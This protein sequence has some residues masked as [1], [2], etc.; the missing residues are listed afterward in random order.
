MRGFIKV[1]AGVAIAVSCIAIV[2]GLV[3]IFAQNGKEQAQAATVFGSGLAKLPTS[4]KHNFRARSK[5]QR[6]RKL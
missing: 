3:G 2:T 4:G 6:F 5:W 1:V